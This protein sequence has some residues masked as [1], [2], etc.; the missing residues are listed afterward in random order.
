MNLKNF[1]SKFVGVFLILF[2]IM[3]SCGVK[4]PCTSMQSKPNQQKSV[5]C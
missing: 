5:I 2:F 3:Q 1:K 4:K